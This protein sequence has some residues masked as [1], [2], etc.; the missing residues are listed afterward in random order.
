MSKI[1]DIEP[2]GMYVS[3]TLGRSC[4]TTFVKGCYYSAT[5]FYEYSLHVSWAVRCHLPAQ[6]GGDNGAKAL[7]GL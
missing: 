4:L 1:G 3:E 2:N 5:R 7:I 6:E